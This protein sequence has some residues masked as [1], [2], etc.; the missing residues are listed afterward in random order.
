M[1]GCITPLTIQMNKKQIIEPVSRLKEQ[2]PA[3]T[4]YDFAK[5]SEK[6]QQQMSSVKLSE[7]LEIKRTHRMEYVGEHRGISFINDSRSS[8]VNGLWYALETLHDRKLVLI[9]G[10]QDRGNDYSIVADQVRQSVLAIVCIGVNN[11]RIK[12]TFS[13]DVPVYEAGSMIDAMDLCLSVA[14]RGEVVLLSPACASF[15]R[16]KDYE[17]R[18]NQFKEA[19]KYYS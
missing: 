12:E 11:T 9:M 1:R 10:G 19:V 7:I 15:D 3:M 2:R 5:A 17:D 8:N 14:K 16:Y 18:G 4:I 13:K 6:D